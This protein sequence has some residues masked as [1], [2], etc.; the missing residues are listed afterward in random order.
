VQISGKPDGTTLQLSRPL[1]HRIRVAN[2]AYASRVDVVQN[3][4]MRMG[5]VVWA[6]NSQVGVAIEQR[7]TVGCSVSGARLMG[8]P[9]RSWWKQGI[10]MTECWGCSVDD[11]ATD[12]PVPDGLRGGL[13]RHPVRRDGVFRH[14]DP[15]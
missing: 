14:P 5:T 9:G 15:A 1:W 10:R 13:R 8:A 2:N 3:S 11:V 7:M 4:H 6:Q 12:E